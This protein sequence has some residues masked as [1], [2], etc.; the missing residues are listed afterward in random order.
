MAHKEGD[1]VLHPFVSLVLQEGDVNKFPL[2]L[3]PESLD[4]FIRVCKQGFVSQ[5]QRRMEMTRD[6]YDLILLAK[7]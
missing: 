6:L 4:P 2:A 1:L 7:T 5:P 3:G